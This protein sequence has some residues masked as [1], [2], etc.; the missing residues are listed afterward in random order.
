MNE[1]SLANG[2][3]ASRIEPAAPAAALMLLLATL[4]SR[5]LS[6]LV[7]EQFGWR[8]MFVLA[9]GAV[10][11][12]GIVAWKALPAFPVNAGLGYGQLLR[13]LAT[14]WKKHPALRRAAL[15]QGLLAVG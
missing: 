12:I 8:T 14:V 11:A 1:M 4:L 7:A 10:A 3:V 2:A 13:S 9:A 5:V 6:G 15:A